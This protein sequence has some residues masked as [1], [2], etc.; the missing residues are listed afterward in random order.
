MIEEPLLIYLADDDAE[1]RE[2]VVDVFK[3]IRPSISITEFDNGVT[4]MDNLLNPAKPLPQ[5]IYLDLNM[6]L[7]NGIECLHD[8]KDEKKLRDIP[9]FIYSNNLETTKIEALQEKGA[10]LYIVKP[11]S[12]QNLKVLLSKSLLY[13]E[14]IKADPTFPWEFVLTLE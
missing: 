4:L 3:D 1:D 7:M 10:N 2:L 8:I 9:I 14:S 5:A 6:P 12:F 11:N 13:L